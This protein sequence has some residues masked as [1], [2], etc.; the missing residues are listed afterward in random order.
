M[1]SKA[2][3]IGREQFV[4]RRITSSGMLGRVAVVRTDV[5]EDLS[6]S[7]IRVTTIGELGTVAVT[8]T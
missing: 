4:I 2:F 5:L 3:T 6:T 1:R 8:S 7:I